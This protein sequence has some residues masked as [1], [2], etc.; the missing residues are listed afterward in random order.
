MRLYPSSTVVPNLF[1]PKGTFGILRGS[2]E[3]HL[4]ILPQETQNGCLRWQIQM[5]YLS[6]HTSWKR[7]LEE[8]LELHIDLRK[9]QMPI[10]SPH[11]LMEKS[12]DVTEGS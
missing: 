11:S 3:H 1:E 4:R 5:E 8:K 10:S 12:F 9:L 6:S 2:D 7:D